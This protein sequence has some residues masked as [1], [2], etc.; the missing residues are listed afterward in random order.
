MGTEILAV[1]GGLEGFFKDVIGGF[2]R[3]GV[4]IRTA[5]EGNS[6]GVSGRDDLGRKRG[7]R[8]YFTG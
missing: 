6:E 3:M 2:D 4:V 8:P 5:L 7:G 1:L